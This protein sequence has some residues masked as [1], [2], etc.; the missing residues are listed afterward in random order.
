MGRG[1][2]KKRPGELRNREKKR[3]RRE[4]KGKTEL[5]SPRQRAKSATLGKTTGHGEGKQ[6]L[7]KQKPAKPEKGGCRENL[8]T[9]SF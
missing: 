3:R 4:R 6:I 1:K 7:Q 2:E 5:N 9:F 8:L